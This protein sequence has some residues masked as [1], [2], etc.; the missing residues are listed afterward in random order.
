MPGGFG[1]GFD[2]EDVLLEKELVRLRSLRPFGETDFAQDLMIA[3]L[4]T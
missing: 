1:R 3:R 4:F 2:R